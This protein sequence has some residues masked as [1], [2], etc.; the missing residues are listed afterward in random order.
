ML[1]DQGVSLARAVRRSPRLELIGPLEDHRLHS[2]LRASGVGPSVHRPP[3]KACP[4]SSNIQA[5]GGGGHTA[6]STD[7]KLLPYTQT[8]STM[9]FFLYTASTF[10]TATYSPEPA[11]PLPLGF[12]VLGFGF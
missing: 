7:S 3:A 11:G 6:T 5:E 2:E 10:S 4:D 1:S 9:A 8:C 12:R